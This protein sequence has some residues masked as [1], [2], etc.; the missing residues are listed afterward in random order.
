[1][2]NTALILVISLS[3]TFAF[4]Q[5]KSIT[6]DTIP[7]RKFV[8]K[9]PAVSPK[10]PG[11]ARVS[12]NAAA[13]IPGLNAIVK[14][15]AIS[16][17]ANKENDPLIARINGLENKYK[18]ALAAEWKK[19][20]DIHIKR[21][22]RKG[23]KVTQKSFLEDGMGSVQRDFS[24]KFYRIEGHQEMKS[25][26]VWKA[27]GDFLDYVIEVYTND[28][29]AAGITGKWFDEYFNVEGSNPRSDTTR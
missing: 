17:A 18:E 28:M 8:I 14:T 26:G 29:E 21:A 6:E 15:P 20:E 5:N 23:E 19:N 7:S 13:K 2:K 9:K 3:S 24:S 11:L 22:A 10:A 27:Y 1:M 16:P 25:K 4:S 12:N